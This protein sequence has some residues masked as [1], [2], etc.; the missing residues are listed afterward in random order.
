[1]ADYLAFELP[2]PPSTNAIW[3]SAG[4]RVHKSSPYQQWIM[5]AGYMLSA[6]VRRQKVSGPIGIELKFVRPNRLRMDLD[7][8]I[9]PILDLLV[10]HQVIEDDHLVQN[11]SAAWVASGA[12]V[13]VLVA[14]TKEVA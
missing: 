13:Q 8:R 4:G 11:I 9:K 12:P 2:F 14:S 6:Q 1:M 3:R 10:T 7:N 5:A